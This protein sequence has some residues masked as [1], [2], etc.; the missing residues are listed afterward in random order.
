MRPEGND[1]ERVVFLE[2]YSQSKR[3]LTHK[4]SVKLINVGGDGAYV[5]RQSHDVNPV[6]YRYAYTPTTT[7]ASAF[8]V[9][10]SDFRTMRIGSVW[11]E[12]VTV[13]CKVWD[14]LW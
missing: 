3:Y 1:L 5:K 6:D 4:E 8:W 10:T 9:Y 2:K 11:K 7:T 12:G 14:E 13:V